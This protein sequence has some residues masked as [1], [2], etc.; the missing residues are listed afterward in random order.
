MRNTLISDLDKRGLSIIDIKLKA[1]KTPEIP[2]LLKSKGV[3]SNILN[4]SC[5]KRNVDINYVLK[6]SETTEKK[7]L[8]V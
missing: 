8:M 7:A 4:S 1:L 3:L 5:R 6:F 2:K